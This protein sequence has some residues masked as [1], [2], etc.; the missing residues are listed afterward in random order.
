METDAEHTYIELCE[1]AI[2]TFEMKIQP[3]SRLKTQLRCETLTQN[4]KNK[5]GIAY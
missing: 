3:V 1:L 5:M 2:K 4:F